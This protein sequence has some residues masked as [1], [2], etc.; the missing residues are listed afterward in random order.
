[1]EGKEE[2]GQSLQSL[3]MK[4][5]KRYM[6][7]CFHQVMEYGIYPGQIPVLILLMQSDGYSQREIAEIL[8]VKPPTVNVT[9][10]RLEKSGIV[11]RRPDERD[12][13]V[14]RV[15][16]TGE[17]KSI[18]SRTKERLKENEKLLFDGFSETELCLM[19]H[20]LLQMLSNLESAPD[21][22]AEGKRSDKTEKREVE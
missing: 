10:Q 11:C 3:F 20:F 9:I 6:T 16:L 12:Q 15:Y 8:Q 21:F 2:G 4:I 5:Q 18:I 7:R 19:R 1:M 22:P 13:R 17:G 14:T